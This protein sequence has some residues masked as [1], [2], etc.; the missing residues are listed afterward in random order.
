MNLEDK[1]DKVDIVLDRSTEYIEGLENQLIVGIVA[2]YM[3]LAKNDIDNFYKFLK[4]N[5]AP[6]DQDEELH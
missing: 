3:K 4:E 5:A 1:I 6:T 2:D